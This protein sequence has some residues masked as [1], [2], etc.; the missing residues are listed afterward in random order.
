[1]LSFG[2]MATIKAIMFQ[3]LVVIRLTRSE[4]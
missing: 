1:M 4:S 2:L 3:L